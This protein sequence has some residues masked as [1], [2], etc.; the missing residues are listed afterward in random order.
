MSLQKNFP[1]DRKYYFWAI[2]LSHLIAIDDA[3]SEIDRK[4][5][6]TLA[7]RMISKAADDV[8]E[9]VGL[10]PSI[11]LPDSTGHVT[12]LVIL[13]VSIIESSPSHPNI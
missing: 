5:F 11:D 4:L 13:T 3:S 2:F 10:S 7:Y 1:K 9:S 12:D 6:G 8:P